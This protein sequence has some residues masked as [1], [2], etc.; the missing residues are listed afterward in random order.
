MANQKYSKEF[1]TRVVQEYL[2]GARMMDVVRKNGISS[3]SVLLDWKRKYL[4]K[5]DITDDRR[6]CKHK[7][8]PAKAAAPTVMT[9][10]EYIR[11]LEMENAILKRLRSLSSSQPNESI[12]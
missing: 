12:K 2:S 11:Y 4:E 9:R 8:N 6:G 5:G 10:D 7:R 3:K 1:K